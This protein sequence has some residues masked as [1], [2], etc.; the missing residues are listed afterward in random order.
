MTLPEDV[1]NARCPHG[2]PYMRCKAKDCNDYLSNLEDEAA[3]ERAE[4]EFNE[5]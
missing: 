5:I 2:Q 1:L 3:E 4:I